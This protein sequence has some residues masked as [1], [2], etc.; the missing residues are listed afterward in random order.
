MPD[1]EEETTINNLLQQQAVHL[2]DTG[3]QK[4]VM[5]YKCLDSASDYVEK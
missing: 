3:T 4:L 5:R 2:F 1:A